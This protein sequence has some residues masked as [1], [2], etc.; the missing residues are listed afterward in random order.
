MVAIVCWF[1][2]KCCLFDCIVIALVGVL[3]CWILLF[4]LCACFV[5]LLGV[6]YLIVLF[7]WITRFIVID[8]VFCLD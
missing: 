4:I 2:F 3:L 5:I 8:I 7:G 6:V 1:C